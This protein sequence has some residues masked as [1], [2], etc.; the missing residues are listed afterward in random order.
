MKELIT[1]ILGFSLAGLANADILGSD[2]F[3]S[4][5]EG[6][7]NGENGG[8]NWGS[9][10]TADDTVIDVVAPATELSYTVPGG[11]TLYGGDRSLRI[12]G[13]NDNALYRSLGQTFGNDSG[14]DNFYVSMLIR[15]D[16]GATVDNLF[17]TLW[18]DNNTTETHTSQPNFGLKMNEAGEGTRDFM[19]RLSL[20]EDM[21]FVED[22]GDAQSQTYMLVAHF[23]KDMDP[24][25][26]DSYN[27]FS[28]MEFWVNPSAADMNTPD[29]IGESTGSSSTLMESL[30]YVGFR[31]VNIDNQE[32]LVDNLVFGT[33]FTD[34][35]PEPLTISLV[36]I[37]GIFSLVIRRIFELG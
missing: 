16:S 31:S 7:L 30:D 18:I 25:N 14:E 23:Y 29:A 33:T 28:K 26:T 34:V 3:Q 1:I 8:Q 17:V 37:L 9:S 15:F 36:A 35:I 4:Y 19:A 27:K 2:D 6:G 13:S 24:A 11:E 22:I 12:S 10:W 5:S 21:L 20:N 32:I